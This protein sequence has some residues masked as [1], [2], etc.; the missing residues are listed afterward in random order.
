VGIVY[1]GMMGS[2]WPSLAVQWQV[3]AQLDAAAASLL[4][5]SLRVGTPSLPIKL[6]V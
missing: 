4:R 2:A 3:A 5:S 6:D 1:D